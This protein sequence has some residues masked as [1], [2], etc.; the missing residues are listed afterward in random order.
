MDEFNGRQ[1]LWSIHIYFLCIQQG[2]LNNDN[3]KIGCKIKYLSNLANKRH[4]GGNSSEKVRFLDRSNELLHIQLITL[5][6]VK[7][8]LLA[9]SLEISWFFALTLAGKSCLFFAKPPE[10]LTH[11]YQINNNESFL[12]TREIL[13]HFSAFFTF[14]K[15]KHQPTIHT[16]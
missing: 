16:D 10:Y 5:L 2:S 9:G 15:S 6:I 4:V 14:H 8:L 3:K 1:N 11:L 7:C 13:L 12:M